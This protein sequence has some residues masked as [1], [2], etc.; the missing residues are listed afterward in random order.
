MC[1]RVGVRPSYMKCWSNNLFSTVLIWF[2][3]VMTLIRLYQDLRITPLWNPRPTHVTRCTWLEFRPSYMTHSYTTLRVKCSILRW[4]LVTL[5]MHG[6]SADP[7]KVTWYIVRLKKIWSTKIPRG[8]GG[9]AFSP[10]SIYKLPSFSTERTE[11][12]HFDVYHN[13]VFGYARHSVRLK[14]TLDIALWV[15]SKMETKN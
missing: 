1:T 14:S 9:S 11:K 12:H 5:S 15:K 7:L 10:W 3:L 2:D 13:R 4:P 6:K 8:V